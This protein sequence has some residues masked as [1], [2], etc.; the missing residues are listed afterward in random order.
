MEAQEERELEVGKN[1]EEYEEN[2]IKEIKYE[3]ESGSSESSTNPKIRDNCHEESDYGKYLNQ[4]VENLVFSDE[5]NALKEVKKHSLATSCLEENK[6]SKAK[7]YYFEILSAYQKN[8]FKELI[9]S[10]CKISKEFLNNPIEGN[11]NT[12]FDLFQVIILFFPDENHKLKPILEKYHSLTKAKIISRAGLRY[13][14]INDAK[15]A[16]QQIIKQCIKIIIRQAFEIK[17]NGSDLNLDPFLDSIKVLLI[18]LNDLIPSPDGSEIKN[19]LDRCLSDLTQPDKIKQIHYILKI[20]N[21]FNLQDV[22]DSF[23]VNRALGWFYFMLRVD[24]ISQY[25][26]STCLKHLESDENMNSLQQLA[27]FHEELGYA[28]SF[29]VKEVL[30]IHHFS[31]SFAIRQRIMK[32]ITDEETA[33][34]YF[35]C[36]LAFQR[37]GLLLIE[38]T[39]WFIKAIIQLKD[40]NL[41]QVIKCFID[42][43]YADLD[44][45]SEIE[46]SIQ[47]I[48]ALFGDSAHLEQL[49]KCK[50]FHPPTLSPTPSLENY[51]LCHHDHIRMC[52]S[53]EN[54]ITEELALIPNLIFRGATTNLSGVKQ[55][56]NY[57]PKERIF[58]PKVSYENETKINSLSDRQISSDDKE[59]PTLALNLFRFSIKFAKKGNHF[60]KIYDLS[61]RKHNGHFQYSIKI[62]HCKQNLDD[63]FRNNK[64]MQ[65]EVIGIV[66]DVISGFLIMMQKRYVHGNINPRNLFVN[67]YREAK[68]GGFG[69]AKKIEQT[70]KALVYIP[71]PGAMEY[72][73][74]EMHLCFIRKNEHL[75]CYPCKSDVFSLGLTLLTCCG[76][77]IE[78]LNDLLHQEFNLTQDQIILIDTVNT[79][80]LLELDNRTEEDR[81]FYYH[82][83]DQLQNKIENTLHKMTK[84]Q[85]LC[86]ILQKMLRVNPGERAAF[87][88][89]AMLV[90]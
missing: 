23:Q 31:E 59:I 51:Q 72:L 71:N 61:Q 77:S 88:E 66:R 3:D 18:R 14:E 53:I 34:Y 40:Y 47:E 36:G 81:A 38:A 17:I 15:C 7:I 37:K 54:S 46:L 5:K 73:S 39:N 42:E 79:K 82:H 68:I 4:K 16:S 49:K 62:E 80:G 24:D 2:L 57:S 67:D 20:V 48:A 28:Y 86:P 69:T 44:E 55:R 1:K 52:E 12:P 25:Y 78:G 65:C 11:K 70:D 22:S 75:V 41:N 45:R 35:N 83:M 26:F 33:R 21:K 6:I 50:P 56:K 63:Y 89:L 19:I 10:A 60:L 84:Y 27:E 13:K 87:N 29:Y 43:S 64:L 85:Y 30:S 76:E 9:T 32:E 74:P 90:R 8:K 58:F